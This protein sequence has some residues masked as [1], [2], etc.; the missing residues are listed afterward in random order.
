ME[1][2]ISALKKKYK[3]VHDENEKR[4]RDDAD[5]RRRE[6]AAK[7]SGKVSK[8]ATISESGAIEVVPGATHRNTPH[9]IVEVQLPAPPVQMMQQTDSN[10]LEIARAQKA[11]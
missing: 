2:I 1:G 9:H 6:N 10:V 11:R 3:E 4:K 7:A 8:P 5:R